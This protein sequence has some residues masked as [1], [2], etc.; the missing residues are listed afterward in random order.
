M[1]VR[2]L[3]PVI[4]LILL[5]ILLGLGKLSSGFPRSLQRLT[6]GSFVLLA[7][8]GAVQRSGLLA[9]RLSGC[10]RRDPFHSSGCYGQQTRSLLAGIQYFGDHSTAQD[11]VMTSAP[12]SVHYLTGRLTVPSWVLVTDKPG[13]LT[14]RLRDRGIRFVLLTGI[15][16]FDRGPLA[17]SLVASCHDLRVEAQF[18]PHSLVLALVEADS[19]GENACETL[20]EF[21]KETQDLSDDEIR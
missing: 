7:G 19:G 21:V 20:A 4:P 5:T 11:V 12:A 13:Q 18:E 17:R 8:L 16:W 2:L 1:D 14:D 6:T 3:F 15:R 10:D 9:R